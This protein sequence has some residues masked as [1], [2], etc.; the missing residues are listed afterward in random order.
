M[1]RAA[2]APGMLGAGMK[3][4][5]D[6]IMAEIPGSG[7]D[8]LSA[9]NAGREAGLNERIQRIT[10]HS[11]IRVVSLAISSIAGDLPV[12]AGFREHREAPSSIGGIREK[13][14]VMRALPV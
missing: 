4:G 2:V 8:R 14:W 9:A 3:R 11:V 12:P 7:L 13:V 10:L 1:R 5:V 6:V